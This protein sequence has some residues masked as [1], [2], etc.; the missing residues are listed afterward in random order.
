LALKDIEIQ[1][2]D[3][4]NK[5]SFNLSWKSVINQVVQ[6][7]ETLKIDWFS[8]ILVL[9]YGK[10]VNYV[11]MGYGSTYSNYILLSVKNGKLA[12]ERKFNNK[13]YE[14][15]K[16]R[17]FQAFKKTEEY[18]KLVSESKKNNMPDELM[19]SFFRSFVVNYTSEF[20]DEEKPP[21]KTKK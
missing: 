4:S 8:G 10:M 21:K 6:E 18:K 2:S 17:Q 3:N 15:F 7:G 1:V 12:G 13:E 19:D 5:G 14:K 20:L 16:E 9:P 11:H